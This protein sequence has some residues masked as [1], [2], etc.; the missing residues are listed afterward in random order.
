MDPCAF[1][2]LVRSLASAGTRR[3][4]M[5][6]LVTLSLGGVVTIA[7]EDAAAEHPRDRLQRRAKQRNRKQ[8]N[9]KQRN[10]RQR[11]QNNGSG[12]GGGS[13]SSTPC[14]ST[15]EC[16]ANA[17]CAGGTCVACDVCTRGC[18]FTSIQAAINAPAQPT[19]I[20]ICPGTYSSVTIRRSLTLVGAGPDLDPTRSLTTLDGGDEP[21]PSLVSIIGSAVS[22]TLQGLGITRGNNDPSPVGSGLGGGIFVQGPATLTMTTCIVSN[23]AASTDGGGLY[24][25]RGTV[26]LNNC[27]VLQNSAQTGQGGGIYID[28]GTLTLNDTLVTANTARNGLGGGVY[29]VAATV[30]LQGSSSI[31][32]NIP[33]DCAGPGGC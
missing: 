26:T 15:S 23:N 28:Q 1:D 13:H 29:S 9:R 7:P 22:V 3:R 11:N 33:D 31:A 12:G 8:R 6:A 27:L 4:L 21:G 17:L 19:T 32:R 25:Q 10:R 24:I 18:A 2:T 30:T 5:R 14:T 16:P 20:H